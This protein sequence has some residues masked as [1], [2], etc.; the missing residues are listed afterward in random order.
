MNQHVS[1]RV[2]DLCSPL[3]PI[4]DARETFHRGSNTRSVVGRGAG[5]LIARW[6]SC[7]FINASDRVD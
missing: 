5:M 3:L 4:I 6:P 7:A 2:K 1:C